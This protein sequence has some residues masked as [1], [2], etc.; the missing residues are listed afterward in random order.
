MHLTCHLKKICALIAIGS[1]CAC[2]NEVQVSDSLS[3]TSSPTANVNEETSTPAMKNVGMNQSNNAMKAMEAKTGMEGMDHSH[4]PI[5][6]PEGVDLPGLSLTL[7]KDTQSGFNLQ[8]ITTAFIL[9][10]PPR[11]KLSMEESMQATTDSRTG[12]LEGHAH[13]YING[14][15]IQR[16]YGHDVHI[17]QEL[18][19]HGDNQI[20]VT[21][22]NHGHMYWI[23]DNR[24]V[25]ATL[26]V[27]P[28][29]DPV[30]TNRF[31]SFPAYTNTATSVAQ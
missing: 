25:L 15:K 30:I 14:E 10:P 22:N 27:N 31:E 3:N 6:V 9:G 11:K 17:P 16:V 8:L 18:I 12:F 21:L 23:I 28:M 13:L 26:F 20:T 24:Q 2:G 1:I 7:Y 5:G 4:A 19:S 29:S